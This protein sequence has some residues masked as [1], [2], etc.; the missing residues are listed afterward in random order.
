MRHSTRYHMIALGSADS[1][2]I[3]DAKSGETVTVVK[4]Q[5]EAQR[6]LDQLNRE[7]QLR[8]L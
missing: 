7:E 2:R 1:F 5:E 8:A 3:T 4:G 6:R